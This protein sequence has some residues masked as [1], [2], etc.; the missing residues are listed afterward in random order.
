MAERLKK[1]LVISAINIHEGGPLTALKDCLNSASRTLGRDYKIVALVHKKKLFNNKGISFA[2]FPVS[3]KSWVFRMYYEYFRFNK[4][5]S[6][7]NSDI[8]LS[9]H[10]ITPNVKAKKRIVYCHNPSP[11]FK[12]NYKDFFYEPKLYIF[13]KLY[14]YLYRFNLKK[15]YLIVVQQQWIKK[16]FQERYDV[17]QVIVSHPIVSDYRRSYNIR[18]NNFSFF[19]PVLPRAFKNIEVLCEAATLLNKKYSNSFDIYLTLDGNENRYAK[20]LFSKFQDL[21]NIHFVGRLSRIQMDDYYSRSDCLVF[22]SRME[23]WGLPISEAKNFNI[24][25]LVADLP[26]A[27]ETI[28][29]YKKVKFFDPLDAIYLSRIMEMVMNNKLQFDKNTKYKSLMPDAK[30]WDELFLLMTE[31]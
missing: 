2:E 23:T 6:L 15:N 22:P 21:K 30:N 10:D 17:D 8:W 12:L 5:S 19:Y 29:K 28:G 1:T 7:V 16:K 31:R 25:I 4:L 9:F 20:D 26:Y 11:F 14:D 13:N 27:H 3:K 24:P 18:N